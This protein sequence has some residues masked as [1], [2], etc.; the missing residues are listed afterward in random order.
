MECLA[1]EEDHPMGRRMSTVWYLTAGYPVAAGFI[2][3]THPRELSCVQKSA[4]STG[5]GT[6]WG[7][8]SRSRHCNLHSRFPVTS[9]V[10]GSIWHL[11]NRFR[12]YLQCDCIS[13]FPVEGRL[14][15]HLKKYPRT[16]QKHDTDDNWVAENSN[17]YRWSSL[18][19][20]RAQKQVQDADFLSLKTNH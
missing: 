19:Q 5:L 1:V 3:A 20:K 16:L 14:K 13:H 6:G 4:V 9:M 2:R 11:A 8:S 15:R 7:C 18:N 10:P 17:V 12:S